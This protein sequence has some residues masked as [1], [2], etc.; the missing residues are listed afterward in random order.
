MAG[1]TIDELLGASSTTHEP[2][3]LDRD[4]AMQALEGSES[5]DFCFAGN[6]EGDVVPS[7]AGCESSCNKEKVLLSLWTCKRFLGRGFGLEMGDPV[8]EL[9][10]WGG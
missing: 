4:S 6:K 1:I 8:A 9:L 7:S 3:E 2:V 10:I 5:D